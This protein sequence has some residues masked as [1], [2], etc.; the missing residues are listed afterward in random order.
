MLLTHKQQ[1]LYISIILERSFD[2]YSEPRRRNRRSCW[3]RHT[4]WNCQ[5]SIRRWCAD[6]DFKFSSRWGVTEE[7]L[8]VFQ[9]G[10]PPAPVVLPKALPVGHI[11]FLARLKLGTRWNLLSWNCEHFVYW[12]YG[13]EPT[14]PQLKQAS[15][16][17]GLAALLMTFGKG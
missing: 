8:K 15:I 12:A 17:V 1:F 14:S 11:L 9:G 16:F 5:R 2:G 10:Y 6:G 7:P 4:H 3:P 13:L